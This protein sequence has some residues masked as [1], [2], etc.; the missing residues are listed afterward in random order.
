MPLK[1]WFIAH[2]LPAWYSWLTVV[3]LTVLSNLLT[4]LV[5]LNLSSN[6][7]E[8]ERRARETAAAEARQSGEVSRR[9]LCTVIKTQEEVFTSPSTPTG[10]KAADAWRDLGRIFRCEN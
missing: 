4:L 2:G 10:L 1:R 3:V 5:V 7:V 6:A 8:N 9:A